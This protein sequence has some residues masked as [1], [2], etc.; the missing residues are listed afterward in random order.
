ME[1]NNNACTVLSTVWTHT[2]K[3]DLHIQIRKISLQNLPK[4]PLGLQILCGEGQIQNPRGLTL[5]HLTPHP[6]V[7]GSRGNSEH[8]QC[9]PALPHCVPSTWHTAASVKFLFNLVE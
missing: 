2:Q 9:F 3:C 7:R 6:P 8:S 5:V 1:Q 4:F